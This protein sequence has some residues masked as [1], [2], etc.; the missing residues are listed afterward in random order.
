M[1]LLLVCRICV[2]FGFATLLG[3]WFGLLGGFYDFIW[4][5]G[6]WFILGG[7]VVWGFVVLAFCGGGVL[8]SGF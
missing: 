4:L 1:L 5:V 6:F 3:G 2:G 8:G 7:L